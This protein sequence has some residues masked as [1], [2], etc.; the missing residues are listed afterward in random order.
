M[1][2][3]FLDVG[4]VDILSQM[5]IFCERHW[6]HCRVFSSI[7]GL[8]RLDARNTPSPPSY[9]HHKSLQTVPIPYVRPMA[10]DCVSHWIPRIQA[11]RT[12][13]WAPCLKNPAWSLRSATMPT[14]HH[15]ITSIKGECIISKCF[16]SM[17]RF[18]TNV[19]ITSNQKVQ[20]RSCLD[21]M[22]IDMR[23]RTPRI[24]TN[25]QPCIIIWQLCQ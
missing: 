15:L 9:D 24:M 18:Y 13:C 12:L 14:C 20:R 19:P 16:H 21:F 7:L 25:Q 5:A 2:A 22:I 8:Y 23:L 3:G 4:T 1:Q 10:G 11:R 17:S 6:M